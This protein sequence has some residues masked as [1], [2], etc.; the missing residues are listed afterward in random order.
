MRAAWRTYGKSETPYELADLE[1]LV[2]EITGDAE[3]AEEFF[4]RYIY[5]S[6]LPDYESLL[7]LAGLELRL[8]NDGKPSLGLRTRDDGDGLEVSSVVRGG[9]A[10]SAGLDRGDVLLELG[11]KPIGNARD[12]ANVVASFEPGAQSEIVFTKRH[13][14]RRAALVLEQDPTLEVVTFES[15]GRQVTPEIEAFR[16]AWLSSS[17]E[18]DLEKH[19]HQCSRSFPF[20]NDYC[21]YDGRKLEM[22]AKP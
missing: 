2:A 7:E 15:K 8:E 22:F 6:E 14:R 9:P 5:D 4:A 21:P 3:F 16:E 20:D 17:L 19:C 18:H 13:E 10:Y 1:G 11:G 12:L